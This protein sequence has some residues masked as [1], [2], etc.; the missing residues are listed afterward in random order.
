M[1]AVIGLV[2]GSALVAA[3]WAADY[4]RLY[5]YGAILFGTLL[6]SDLGLAYNLGEALVGVGALVAGIGIVLLLR[7]VR[8][9]PRSRE[10]E[11][12]RD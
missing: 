7:F 1:L 9:Y 5:A 4:P 11:V 2:W 10:Q 8:R 6:G 3:G 12:A